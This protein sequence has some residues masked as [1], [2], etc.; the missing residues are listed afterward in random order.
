MLVLRFSRSIHVLCSENYVLRR[1]LLLASIWY[2][3]ILIVCI[4]SLKNLL[5]CRSILHSDLWLLLLLVFTH[6]LSAE[7]WLHLLSCSL[8]VRATN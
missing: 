4:S 1:L 5:C 3:A 2:R 7:N 8:H 6:I